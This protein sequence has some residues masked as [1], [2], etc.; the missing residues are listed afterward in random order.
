M[1]LDAASGAYHAVFHNMGGCAAVGCHAFSADGYTWCT[2]RQASMPAAA[3]FH[4]TPP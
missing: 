2:W 4:A 3:L 1:W